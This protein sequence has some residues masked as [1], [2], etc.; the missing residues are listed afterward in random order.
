MNMEKTQDN[1][2]RPVLLTTVADMHNIRRYSLS[3]Q[4]VNKVARQ[5]RSSSFQFLSLFLQIIS[6]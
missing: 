1:H 4:P 3:V 5:V 2:F 6:I